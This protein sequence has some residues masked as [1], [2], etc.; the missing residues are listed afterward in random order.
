MID[1]NTHFMKCDS[2][3]QWE[4]FKKRNY[5]GPCSILVKKI[6][7]SMCLLVRIGAAEWFSDWSLQTNS[8]GYCGWSRYFHI[9]HG[10]HFIWI[11]V[12]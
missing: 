10:S 1:F 8:S 11:N 7:R 2:A 4:Q 9:S 5:F 12:I 3:K 6:K